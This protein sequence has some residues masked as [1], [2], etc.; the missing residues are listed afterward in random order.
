M[1]PDEEDNVR[2]I[3]DYQQKAGGEG[4]KAILNFGSGGGT[5]GGMDGWQ[6][7]V[8]ARL[9][10]I[11]T[12]VRELRTAVGALNT[13]V[14]TLTERVAHLPSK[15]YMAAWLIAAMA[16]ITAVVTFQSTIQAFF[17]LPH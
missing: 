4:E 1:P 13:N 3:R 16:L 9:G 7:S 14:A 8:E 2:H 6:T 11:N 10:S 17:K 12:D 15:G 5:S